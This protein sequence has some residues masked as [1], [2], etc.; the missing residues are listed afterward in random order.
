[1]SQNRGFELNL[2]RRGWPL[3]RLFLIILTP[4]ATGNRT[5]V[6]PRNDNNNR[7]IKSAKWLAEFISFLLKTMAPLSVGK[8]RGWDWKKWVS[9]GGRWKV[10]ARWFGGDTR[11]LSK[12]GAAAAFGGLGICVNIIFPFFSA[13]LPLYFYFL[14]WGEIIF[15]MRPD[16]S[17]GKTC[18]GRNMQH[19]KFS[20][21]VA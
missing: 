3:I 4:Q 21:V 19:A 12:P 5:D 18:G 16:E 13:E 15:A 6:Q 10:G 1:M 8:M 2:V 14:R 7:N 9:V 20:R 11:G 17:C